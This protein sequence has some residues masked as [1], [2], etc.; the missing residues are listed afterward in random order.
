MASPFCNRRVQETQ[1][2]PIG[3]PPATGLGEKDQ[4]DDSDQPV[5]K[6][7]ADAVKGS[8][9]PEQSLIT[10]KFIPLWC[11]L[12]GKPRSPAHQA[13]RPPVAEQPGRVLFGGGEAK[14]I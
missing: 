2:Y 5:A 3:S 9:E 8:I 13:H 12:E 6:A 11:S 7:P 4:G 10:G 14:S 1:R